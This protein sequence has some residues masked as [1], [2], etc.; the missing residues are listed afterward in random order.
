ALPA[1]ARLGLQRVASGVGGQHAVGAVWRTTRA[2]E[3][4]LYQIWRYIPDLGSELQLERLL[5][6][7]RQRRAGTVRRW[8][9]LAQCEPEGGGI[10]VTLCGVV[11]QR[12]Q[13]DLAQRQCPFL[14]G[15]GSR[16]RARAQAADGCRASMWK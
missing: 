13:G 11:G 7:T 4:L 16:Q 15:T 10:G 5:Y 3:R 1:A 2:R 14:A 12:T 6:Q 9:V 8:Q